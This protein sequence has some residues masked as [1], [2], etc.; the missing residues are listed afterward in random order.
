M[1]LLNKENFKKIEKERN[2][3]HER[4]DSTYS[5]FIDNAGNKY[6]QIDNYGRKGRQFEGNFSQ[7]L[8]LDQGSAKYLC[9]IIKEEFGLN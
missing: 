8:Q 4:V 7:T 5:V 6:F 2:F 3:I 1:A 9:K